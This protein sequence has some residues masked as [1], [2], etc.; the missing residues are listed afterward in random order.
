MF[1]LFFNDVETH[2]SNAYGGLTYISSLR[3]NCFE[4]ED[5]VVYL[6][7]FVLLYADY[8]IVLAE[9]PTQL[10]SA[11]NTL[12]KYCETW[13]LHA[14]TA[15]TKVLVFSRSKIRKLPE[16]KFGPNTFAIVDKYNY[17]GINFKYN[18]TFSKA[19]YII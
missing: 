17:L 2:L 15:K 11:L 4:K 10:Q 13:K 5:I 1:A 16:F 6:K 9:S 3:E 7:H 19:Y 8:T 18:G 14:N 12:F